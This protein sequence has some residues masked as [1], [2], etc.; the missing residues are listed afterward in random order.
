MTHDSFAVSDQIV[1][2]F[3]NQHNVQVQFLEVGDTGTAVNKAALSKDNPLADVFYGVDNTFLSRALDEGI[4][5]AYQSPVLVDIDPS[6]QLDPS[7]QALPVD[8]GDVCLNYQKSYFQDAGLEPPKTLDDLIQPAYSGLLTVENPATSSPGLAFLL[9]TVGFYGEDGYL[10]YWRALVNN[11]VNIV[12]D[13][14]TAYYSAFSQAGGP[15]PIVVSYSSSPPFE[16]LFSEEPLDEAPTAAVTT[17][18]SCFRQIE[19]V[20]ILKGTE[21]RQLAEAWVDYMLSPAFQED[22]PL[23]MYVFPVN[24][25]AKL[26][27]TFQRYLDVPEVTADVT[28]AMI[29]EGRERWISDW[30]EA[31]LR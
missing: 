16:V 23:N 17:P 20:G 18:E 2:E 21:H 28:P 15:D 24:R 11:E 6:F 26:D 27:E 22:I 3:E 14:E 31:V 8:F 19:F 12:N 10:D 1:Q 30:T 9:T 25:Q 13:W 4:F 5:E 7:Y 29:A